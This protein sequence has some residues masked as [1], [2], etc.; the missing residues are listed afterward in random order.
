[1][2]CDAFCFKQ[3]ILGLSLLVMYN[4]A[5]RFIELHLTFFSL[6]CLFQLV[7]RKRTL[8]YNRFKICNTFHPLENVYEFNVST[9]AEQIYFI[10]SS[11]G[12]K[13]LQGDI[14]IFG[15]RWAGWRH[16]RDKWSHVSSGA[17]RFTPGDSLL[18]D[19]C[20]RQTCTIWI[21]SL[22]V[23]QNMKITVLDFDVICILQI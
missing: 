5:K 4:E 8:V 22:N 7:G 6:I 21:M 15:V 17:P 20:S 12:R 14:Y 16:Y 18:L 11:L 2:Y 9:K 19:I 23:K 10:F 1:M 13:L 3:V